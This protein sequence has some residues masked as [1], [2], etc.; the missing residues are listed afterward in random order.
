[1]KRFRSGKGS[2]QAAPTSSSAHHPSRQPSTPIL[3][4]QNSNSCSNDTNL[5]TFSSASLNPEECQ[6]AI[7]ESKIRSLLKEL[8]ADVKKCQQERDDGLNNLTS[9]NKMHERLRKEDKST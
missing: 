2:T 5:S 3:F 9:L 1:M 8:Q 6:I 7:K 4:N